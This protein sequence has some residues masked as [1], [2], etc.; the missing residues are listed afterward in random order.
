[1]DR[2]VVHFHWNENRS[3]DLFVTIL[4]YAVCN[5]CGAFFLLFL[6]LS[7]KCNNITIIRRVILSPSFTVHRV[8]TF[9]SNKLKTYVLSQLKCP[10]EKYSLRGSRLFI[11][12]TFFCSPSSIIDGA[13]P[14][15]LL[16]GPRKIFDQPP[17]VTSSITRLTRLRRSP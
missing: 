4:F 2:D 6:D 8:F 12:D 15:A 9:N 17:S 11:E 1:M 5:S 13:I 10:Y 3:K 14:L 7:L 16:P